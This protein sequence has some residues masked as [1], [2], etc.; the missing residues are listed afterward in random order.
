MDLS[1]TSLISVPHFS[2]SY[3]TSLQM[4]T[5]MLTLMLIRVASLPRSLS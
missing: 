5:L 2:D 3:S 1:D 4:L